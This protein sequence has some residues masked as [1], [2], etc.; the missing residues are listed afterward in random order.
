MTPDIKAAVTTPRKVALYA[1]LEIPDYYAVLEVRYV[2]H[3]ERFNTLPNGEVRERPHDRYVRVS[4]PVE[5]RFTAISDDVMVQNAIAALNE[6]ERKAIA[7]L[8]AKVA[9]IR[10]RKAQLLALTHQQEASRG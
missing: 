6:E 2:N 3:D 8:N 10:E 9:D 4:E 7:E 5:I 1:C